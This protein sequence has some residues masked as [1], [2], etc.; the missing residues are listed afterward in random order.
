MI[1]ETHYLSS[2]EFCVGL[3]NSQRKTLQTELSS[4]YLQINLENKFKHA[5]SIPCLKI[6]LFTI[7]SAR[8]ILNEW[9]Y[10]I[11]YPI[12]KKGNV[13][14]CD[15]YRAVTLLCKTHKILEYVLYVK[16]VPYAEAITGE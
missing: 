2:R 16:S 1:S 3:N 11:I 15:K 4:N 13:I 14:G 12:H 8:N 6:F 7:F 5:P 9:K 10:G